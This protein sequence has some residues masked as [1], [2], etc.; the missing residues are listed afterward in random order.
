MRTE[1]T[2]PSTSLATR[3]ETRARCLWPRRCRPCPSQ[4]GRALAAVPW[5]DCPWRTGESQIDM[6]RGRCD[7]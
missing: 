2:E 1:P 7:G 5:V 3:S 4:S 6:K